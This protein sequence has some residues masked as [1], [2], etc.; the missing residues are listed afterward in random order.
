M[1]IIGGKRKIDCHGYI[2]WGNLDDYFFLMYNMKS[3]EQLEAFA[4]SPSRGIQ[5]LERPYPQQRT[6]ARE[7]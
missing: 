7:R 3:P 1:N 5:L 6:Q 2:F 4:N